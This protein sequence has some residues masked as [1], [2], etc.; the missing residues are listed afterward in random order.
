[1]R[2]YWL[3][4]LSLWDCTF[5]IWR[6]VGNEYSIGL[7]VK[8]LPTGPNGPWILG[9][10]RHK[11]FLL[12]FT[13]KEA[14]FSPDL[15]LLCSSNWVFIAV[16]QSPW[17]LENKVQIKTRETDLGDVPN[18]WYGFGAFSKPRFWDSWDKITLRR[19]LLLQNFKKYLSSSFENSCHS[20]F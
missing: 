16:G 9:P 15:F 2:I 8:S 18:T 12:I 7:M 10:R 3:L 4:L 11:C 14:D 17:H 19:K 6:P 5:N 20:P 1:M 13:L